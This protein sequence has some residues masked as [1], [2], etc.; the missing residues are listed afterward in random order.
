MNDLFGMVNTGVPTAGMQSLGTPSRLA[1]LTANQKPM[2]EDFAVVVTRAVRKQPQEPPTRKKTEPNTQEAMALLSGAAPIQ[3]PP[4]KENRETNIVSTGMDVTIGTIAPFATAQELFTLWETLMQN[5]YGSPLVTL[6]EDVQILVPNDLEN[7]SAHELLD[8]LGPQIQAALLREEAALSGQGVP[9]AEEWEVLDAGL[10][11]AQTDLLTEPAV[12]APV[13]NRSPSLFT[14]QALLQR[15]ARLREDASLDEALIK[16]VQ[17]GR[18]PLV[19]GGET[20]IRGKTPDLRSAEGEAADW[21]AE[22]EVP[23]G[24]GHVAALRKEV[25]TVQDNRMLAFARPFMQAAQVS[26]IPADVQVNG[27]SPSQ[28]I[29]QIVQF[30]SLRQQAEGTTQLQLQLNPAHLGRVNIVLTATVVG[31]TAQIRADND[32]TRG[33][34]SSNVQALQTQLKEMGITMKE[35]DISGSE[36]S[37]NFTGQTGQNTAQSEQREQA[38]YGADT[39]RLIPLRSFFNKPVPDGE[40]YTRQTLV[41]MSAPEEGGVDFRA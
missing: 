39:E 18:V 29:S 26:A 21:Q 34:L 41:P 40:I 8:I 13:A 10:A 12:S 23:D 28:I 27:V 19:E 1:R 15:L 33:I 6:L 14:A 31:I 32:A 7:R 22:G 37:R 16:E 36:M 4:I 38:H 20:L 35:I 5:E 11:Q 9:T 17:N 25:P 24:E 30:A 2:S 3:T